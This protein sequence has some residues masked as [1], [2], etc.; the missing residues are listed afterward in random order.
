M[1]LALCMIVFVVHICQ[2]NSA[3]VVDKDVKAY[4]AKLSEEGVLNIS[5]DAKIDEWQGKGIMWLIACYL[6][7]F[8]FPLSLHTCFCYC[9]KRICPRISA[10]NLWSS[11]LLL[12]L[13]CVLCG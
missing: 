5:L 2:V 11:H 9:G 4:K 7:F 10:F 3:K 8:H 13:T 12:L 1:P 6:L